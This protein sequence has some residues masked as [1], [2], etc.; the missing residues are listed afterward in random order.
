MD[1]EWRLRLVMAQG[2][3]LTL[4]GLGVG[5]AVSLAA[6]RVLRA[7]LFGVTTADP[8][9]YA[10]VAVLLCVMALAACYI[11]ARRATKVQPLTAL[12]CE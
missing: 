3:R 8:L 4:T 6:T 2:V 7:S 10:A 9:T 12:H 5:L 11:P 1:Y